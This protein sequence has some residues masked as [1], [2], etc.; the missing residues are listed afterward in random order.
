MSDTFVITGIVRE[1][2]SKIGLPG[3]IVRAYDKD[4][5][6]DDLMGEDRTSCDGSFRIVSEAEDFRDFFDKRPDIYLRIMVPGHGGSAP[7]EVFNT[8]HAVRWNAGHLE[9]IVVEIPHSIACDLPSG[10]DEHSHGGGHS[11]EHGDH[12]SEECCDHEHHKPRHCTPIT[13]CRDIYLKIEKLPAY[14]PVAPDDAEHDK[15]RR[16]CMRNEDHED[17]RIPET[18]VEQRR[19]DALV[20]REY[21]DPNYTIPKNVPLISADVNEPR[22]ERRIPGTLIYASPGERLFVHVCNG[23]DEPHSFHVHGLIYG[24][25]SDGSWPFGV[26][27][28]DGRRSDAI[29]PGQTWCYVFDVTEDTIGAWPFHDHHMH[30]TESVDRGLFGGVVVRD[31]RCP[32]PDY[33]VPLFFHRLTPKQGEAA[34]DSGAL[35]P[36]DT[37]SHTFN[38]EG[39]FNYHCRFHP[40]SGVVRVTTTGPLSE[41]VNI[42]D[43]PGRFDQDDVTIRLGGMVT[44]TH[45]GAEPHTVTDTGGA[46]LESFAFNG[47]TFVGNTPTI[48]ART[49]KRIRWYVFNLD[50]SA[51]WHNFH[52]H[53]QRW[54]VGHETVDTRSLG[55]A[56][57]FVA[58]T[59]V[60]PVILLPLDNDCHS[61]KGHRHD[62]ECGCGKSVGH[63]RAQKPVLVTGAT[64]VGV[65]HGQGGGHAAP[66]TAAPII[67]E[68][69]DDSH[70][71]DESDEE[72]EK[73]RGR[74]RLQGDFLVHCHVE[75]HMMGGMACVVRAIQEVELT[76]ALKD[77]LGFDPPLATNDT[78]PDVPVHPCMHGGAGSWER[79]PDS[80][81]FIVHAAMLRT[82][83]VLLWS[84]AAEVGYPLNSL[85]WDPTNPAD[86]TNIH[87]YSQDLF[88]S[89]H[90]WLPD[91]R[92]CV[93]GGYVAGTFSHSRAT[94]LFDPAA[95]TPW[96][97]VADM[98][99]V[100]WYPTLLTLP[101]GRILAVS[102]QG[103]NRQEIYDAGTNTW[104]FVTGADR[105]FPELYPSLNLLPSGD[106][107]YSRAGWA[108]SNLGQ[109][110]TARLAFTGALSGMWSDL[111]Q[112]QFYDR[113]EG[114][115]VMLIDTTVSPPAT[116]VYIIGGGVSGPATARNPQ[117]AEVIDLTT[118]VGA[119]WS[120][121]ADMNFPRTNVNVVPLPDGTL[122]VI[123][124]QRN[125]KWN[126]NPGAV[127]EAEIYDP[128]TNTWTP[129]APM[130]FPR[131]YHSIAVLLPDGRVL[132]AG[133][134]DPSGVPQRDQHNMEIF[135]P[136]YLSMGPRPTITNAPANVSYGASFDI[137]TPDASQIASVVLLRPASVTHH[138]DAGARYIKI[139]ILSRTA[140]RL[141]LRAPANGNI[142]PPGYYMAFIVD[143]D[144]VPSIARFVRLS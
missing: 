18:E 17:T 39:T 41:S 67:T 10:E 109:P 130:M 46:G 21:L 113:Q 2:E 12:N 104:Q 116:K 16:D 30:I 123:G 98:N 83:K 118:L 93:A 115:A 143:G 63:K 51:G 23:D 92:L 68:H 117:S 111:G 142:A 128:Q 101:D 82:G 73:K 81:I 58:D 97:Q 125:G 88:C 112:Q 19:M 106:V 24:I 108:Q 94:F 127:L 15:Y 61:H 47:R 9:Y 37:F 31:H 87:T 114:T 22:P 35:N 70:H 59:I 124:G 131:Q 96:T 141:T 45:A 121:V 8:A 64:G 43:G 4:L 91:G 34:F 90:A 36:G 110:G 136:G 53:G 3:L 5:L 48:V 99:L 74:V 132:S 135:S 69:M 137:D 57:S 33:E 122:L 133:G 78:C 102:G 14:S 54:D 103:A 105:T 7:R 75:M 32:K 38:E 66:H 40:M 56:E 13:K 50:L 72:A 28:A 20:Y 29:C 84:G 6:Y 138:T 65:G 11:H 44:W 119:A 42:L 55:P 52:V 140:S 49:G 144:N 107:F 79:L 85:V 120:R 1:K 71:H 126:T 86:M 62:K 80:P 95:A 77:A 27:D 129:T 134:V 60:P 89:G 100:R 139:P 76:P 25:D 26:H